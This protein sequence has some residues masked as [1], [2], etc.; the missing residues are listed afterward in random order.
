MF[1]KYERYQFP[2]SAYRLVPTGELRYLIK[3][4][5]SL[6]R[7]A[8]PTPSFRLYHTDDWSLVTRFIDQVR[9][10]YPLVPK[11][12]FEYELSRESKWGPQ[13][14]HAPWSDLEE[15]A[16]MYFSR[17][18]PCHFLPFSWRIEPYSRMDLHLPTLSTTLALLNSNGRVEE[19]ANGWRL[20]SAKKTDEAAQDDA[21]YLAHTGLWKYAF[22]YF[23]SR[24]T[25]NKKRLFVPMPFCINLLQAQYFNGFLQSIQESLLTE[26]SYSPFIFWGDKIGFDQFFDTIM[27]PYFNK[28]I[29]RIPEDDYI[30]V[31]VARDFDKM[32]T[33]TGVSQKMRSLIPRIAAAYHITGYH[34]RNR[35]KDIMLASNYI[36]I[37]T[38]DGMWN[39]AHG[40]ASGATVTNGGETCSNE[41]FDDEFHYQ[42]TSACPYHIYKLGSYGNGDDG[43]SIYAIPQAKI[44]DFSA[45][46]RRCAEQVAELGGFVIQSSKWSVSTEYGVYCQF[47]ISYDSSLKRFRHQYPAS[48][49]LNSIVHPEKQYTPATWDKDYRDLDVVEKLN[50]GW[51]L[52]YFTDLIDYVDSGMKFP[53]LGRTEDETRRILSK[54][55]RYRSLQLSSRNYNILNPEYSADISV[56]PAVRY[57]L[58]KR[59]GT[60]SLG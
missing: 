16:K 53:L 5:N 11:W 13:G 6:S 49:I 45:N 59:Y 54:W 35:M 34:E 26:R 24:F 60:S 51:D 36:P 8:E 21:V 46:V 4:L 14:G 52:Y 2:E 22:A 12:Q 18:K 23:F 50:N 20:F 48:L 28:M 19:R 42:L 57:L 1:L 40:E 33:S 47:M 58:N 32:D 7:G 41:D 31:Y 37:A 56:T 39:G 43:I 27:T 55:D 9:H 29:S 25:K 38:P 3:S 30:V 44:E 15:N 10:R 17:P